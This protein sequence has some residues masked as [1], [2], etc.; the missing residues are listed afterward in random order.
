MNKIITLIAKKIL[1]CIFYLFRIFPINKS[2]VIITNYNGR[3]FGDSAKY[4]VEELHKMNSNLKIVWVVSEYY[5]DM[6]DYIKQVKIYSIKWIYEL[7]TSKVWINNSR[8]SYYVKKRK[9]QP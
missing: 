3:S 8:F 5:K 4:V 9:K 1:S 2:K 6:P 7:V